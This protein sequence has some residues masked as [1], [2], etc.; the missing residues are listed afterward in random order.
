MRRHRLLLSSLLCVL[1]GSGVVFAESQLV[2]ISFT[3]KVLEVRD[4]DNVFK[5]DI[6]PGE[7]VT[8]SIIYDLSAEDQSK[9][10]DSWGAYRFDSDASLMV[11][12]IKSHEFRTRFGSPSPNIP[13]FGVQVGHFVPGSGEPK[14]TCVTSLS[15]RSGFNSFPF[16]DND[17]VAT[18]MELYLSDKN[19]KALDS[20]KL[21]ETIKFEDWDK[22]AYLTLNSQARGAFSYRIVAEITNIFS[23]VVDGGTISGNIYRDGNGDCKQDAGDF[24]LQRRIVEI[25]PGPFYTLSD[26]DGNYAITVP[27]GEYTVATEQRPVWKQVCPADVHQVKLSEKGEESANN[28]FAVQPE[29]DVKALRVSV[30]GSLAR[31]GFEMTY[32]IFLENVG[33]L[34]Y[35]G[36]IVFEHSNILQEFSSDPA[37][38]R[39]AS[40]VAEWD[41][42]NMAVDEVRIIDV[43]LKVPADEK[44][45]GTEICAY[46]SAETD[47]NND[48]LARDKRDEFCQD[49]RGAYDPNDIRV[50]P[51]GDITPVETELTYIIRF[52]NTGNEPAVNVRVEDELGEMFDLRT[53]KVGAASHDY[54]LSVSENG[55]LEWRFENIM[56]PGKEVNESAS[57][58]YIKFKVSLRDGL[59]I[60]SEISNQAAIYFDFN[61]P[62]ITNTVT[63]RI[64]SSSTSVDFD[65]DGLGL[66]L[67]P[68]PVTDK[69]VLRFGSPVTGLVKI[70][71]MI[72]ESTHAP[73]K[74]E[75]VSQH[76]LDLR[77][78]GAG[79]H[80]VS[81]QTAQGVVMKQIQVLR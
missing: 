57:Q 25:L 13:Q 78:L 30:V 60:G 29:A 23:E 65:E 56:L 39:Y 9:E 33:T 81:V 34:P 6:G 49:I 12:N 45:L 71:T 72:G 7:L 16:I 80:L 46:V 48:E 14:D 50:L 76:T 77:G 15:F 32:R 18:Q 70:H 28:D 1:V 69:L 74:L 41:I 79:T 67:Y 36:T 75:N 20:D 63:T 19:C 66:R 10:N 38:D 52:Q 11:V 73:V 8:G 43:K 40:P 51:A 26:R 24:G 4:L 54:I 17:Q 47:T 61:S 37:A 58:G 2:S 27:L 44:L 59:P 42:D 35:S 53:L 21:P 22:P 68:N 55:K 5:N 64:V 62:V 3:A 31:P